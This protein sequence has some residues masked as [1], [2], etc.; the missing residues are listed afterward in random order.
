[1]LKY[2]KNEKETYLKEFKESSLSLNKFVKEKG[3]P[4]TTF[5]GWMKAQNNLSFGELELKT[6]KP[7]TEKTKTSSSNNNKKP[8]IFTSEDIKIELKEDFNKEFLKKIV[9]VLIYAN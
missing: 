8:I 2:N 7:K 5:H 4:Y 9:E 1:M 6:T 3:I